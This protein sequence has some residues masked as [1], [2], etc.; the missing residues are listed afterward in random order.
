[1]HARKYRSLYFSFAFFCLILGCAPIDYRV[2]SPEF[3][4]EGSLPQSKL[5]YY[6]DSFDKFREELWEKA[7]AVWKEEQLANFKFADIQIENGKLK[8][9]TKTGSFSKGT[10]GSKFFLGGNFDIQI[11]CQI[12]FLDILISM[13]QWLYFVVMEKAEIGWKYRNATIIGLIKKAMKQDS[14]IYSNCHDAGRLHTRGKKHKIGNFHGTLRII[15]IGRKI[16]TLYKFEG[17]KEWTKMNTFFPFTTNDVAF[18]FSF[19]N[20]HSRRT[21]IQADRSISATFDNF[22]INAAQRIMEEDI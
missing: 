1:M 18:G 6:N 15:R 21:S 16:H 12:E 20:F 14:I 7:G 9:E 22:K 5:A 2:G 13:D 10:V 4:I 17:S 19:M 3:V 11:D 8:I